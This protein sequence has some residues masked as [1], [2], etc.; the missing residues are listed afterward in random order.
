MNV[1]FTQLNF[2]DYAGYALHTECGFTQKHTFN[3]IVKPQCTTWSKAFYF[4]LFISIHTREQTDL[5]KLAGKN[6]RKASFR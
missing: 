3:S 6:S 2:R 1:F 5:P 4:G